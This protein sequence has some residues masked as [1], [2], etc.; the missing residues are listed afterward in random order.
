MSVRELLAEKGYRQVPK[1]PHYW[2]DGNGN[3]ASTHRQHRGPFYHLKPKTDKDGYLEITLQNNGNRK[4]RKV[5]QVIAEVFLGQCPHG[6]VVNHK[7]GNKQNNTPNNLEYI[8]PADNERHARQVLGKN[9]VGEKASQ[10]KLTSDDVLEIIK[11]RN[12]GKTQREI[13]EKF[14]IGQAQVWRILNKKNWQHIE[15]EVTPMSNR[16]NQKN[17]EMPNLCQ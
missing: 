3:I 2:C 6:H 12:E 7:D 17:W 5:H 8:T 13:S 15:G 11:M 4:C 14:Q 1:W 9:C 10:S 16:R